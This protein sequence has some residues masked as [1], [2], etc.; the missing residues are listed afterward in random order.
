MTIYGH[1]TV[2]GKFEVGWGCILFSCP[3]VCLF[4]FILQG[5][6]NKHCLSMIYE[7][8]FFYIIY[9]FLFGYNMV[10]AFEKLHKHLL[11][12]EAT[13]TDTGYTIRHMQNK[14]F[15]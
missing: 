12:R 13:Q 6:S 5:V 8:L 9:V 15:A 7:F 11:Y 1:Y 2:C 3:S 4:W 10:F 14:T